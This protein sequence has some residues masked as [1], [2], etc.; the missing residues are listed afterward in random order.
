MSKIN[1]I[2]LQSRLAQIRA[3]LLSEGWLYIGANGLDVL[4]YR[5]PRNGNRMTI[6]ADTQEG[7]I[8]Y[9]KNGQLVKTETVA[10]SAQPSASAYPST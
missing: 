6:I 2:N 3:S 5:H 4:H 8:A 10:P 1:E 9:V 7:Q